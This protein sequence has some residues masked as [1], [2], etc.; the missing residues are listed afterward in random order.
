MSESAR[1]RAAG[2]W[3]STKG[4]QTLGNVASHERRAMLTAGKMS[5]KA[6]V[7]ATIDEPGRCAA[8]DPAASPWLARQ[9]RTP[10]FQIGSA[11]GITVREASNAAARPCGDARIA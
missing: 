4:H 3:T 10:G 1:C 6:G 9:L 5:G 11:S 8:K 2:V 7:I